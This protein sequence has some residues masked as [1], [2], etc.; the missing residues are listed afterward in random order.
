MFVPNDSSGV[1][2]AKA[3]RRDGDAAEVFRG[4]DVGLG[5]WG[6]VVVVV[7]LGRERETCCFFQVSK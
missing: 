3:T 7:G 5:F 2:G 4:A 1:L 6:V